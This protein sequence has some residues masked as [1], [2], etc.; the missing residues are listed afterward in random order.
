M[1]L[2][3]DW[4]V[5][6]NHCYREVFPIHRRLIMTE[7]LAVWRQCLRM[8]NSASATN[9]ATVLIKSREEEEEGEEAVVGIGK[10][11]RFVAI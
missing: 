11:G 2:S 7:L 4:K 6:K 10:S 3:R 9:F 5:K 8:I 1:V